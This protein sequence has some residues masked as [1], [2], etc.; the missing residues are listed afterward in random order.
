MQFIFYI[1]AISIIKIKPIHTISNRETIPMPDSVNL[2]N[3]LVYFFGK[4]SVQSLI[5]NWFFLTSPHMICL[6]NTSAFCIICI[7]KPSI[8][9]MAI[10]SSILCYIDVSILEVLDFCCQP[11]IDGILHQ[12]KT[13]L[14]NPSW[15]LTK[16]KITS[17]EN[18]SVHIFFTEI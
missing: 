6:W 11:Y 4:F 8:W 1:W 12:D 14:F 15:C 5:H 7:K 16:F 17:L 2:A 9:I 10:K 18:I 3:S 13:W